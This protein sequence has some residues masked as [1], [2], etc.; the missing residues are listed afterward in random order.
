M[1]E[2]GEEGRAGEGAGGEVGRG[3]VKEEQEEAV[4]VVVCGGGDEWEAGEALQE[5]QQVLRVCTEL[6]QQ[7]E[8]GGWWRGE[9]EFVDQETLREGGVVGV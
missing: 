3:A 4:E 2:R 7:L 1:E 6:A 9:V 5:A 8:T